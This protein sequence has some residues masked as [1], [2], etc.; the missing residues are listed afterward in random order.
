[1]ITRALRQ[2][3]LNPT[4]TLSLDS[5]SDL[6]PEC[7]LRHIIGLG[8]QLNL[9]VLAAETLRLEQ[10]LRVPYKTSIGIG[11]LGVYGI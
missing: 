5:S 4:R 3:S 8:C 9:A 10:R 1:M 6:L 11:I 2:H 7:H